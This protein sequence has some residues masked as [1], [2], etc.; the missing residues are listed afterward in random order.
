MR[1]L[2]GPAKGIGVRPAGAA[3]PHASGARRMKPGTL[4]AR[5]DITGPLG[6]SPAGRNWVIR[7]FK[8]EGKVL[9]TGQRRG[10]R[11]R[12]AEGPGGPGAEG[13]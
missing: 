2:A 1:R 6:L 13:A 3:V 7:Q 11:Y 4:Y 12:L 5:P 9:Q 8:E 10:A